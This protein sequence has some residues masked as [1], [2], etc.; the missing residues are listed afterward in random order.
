M[1]ARPGG[2][3]ACKTA[4]DLIFSLAKAVAFP[5]LGKMSLRG[6]RKRRVFIRAA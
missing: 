5:A 2:G 6:F 3:A 4:D 1:Q